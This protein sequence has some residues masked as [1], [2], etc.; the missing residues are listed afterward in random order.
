MKVYISILSLFFSLF[1]NA[2]TETLTLNNVV[3]ELKKEIKPSEDGE[4]IQ[5]LNL[6]RNGSSKKLLSHTLNEFLGDCNSESIELGNYKVTDSIITFYSFWCT[7]GDAPVS[8]YGAR[9]QVYSIDTT[10]K[11]KLKSS[12]VYIEAG[13]SGWIP[14]LEFLNKKPITPKENKIFKEYIKEIETTYNANFVFDKKAKELLKEVKQQL[15]K[16]I[17]AA[18]KNWDSET[19]F[20]VRM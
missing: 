13:R 12:Q 6:Y 10:G 18:T 14:G 1:I 16:E 5:V 17:E 3:F 8:P 2:Q 19:G 20:G 4:D 9:I 11:I 7:R 15:Q